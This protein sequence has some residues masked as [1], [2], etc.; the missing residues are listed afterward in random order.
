MKP[1][2]LVLLE[3]IHADR[4]AR[5][6]ALGV[7]GRLRFRIR[8]LYAIVQHRAIGAWEILRHG[9]DEEY[10]VRPQLDKATTPTG[11]DDGRE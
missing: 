10:W 5:W 11:G 8:D 2:Y 4:R 3:Q 7:F 9:D 1:A 6:K